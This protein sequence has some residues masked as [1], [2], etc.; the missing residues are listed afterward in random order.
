MGNRLIK[1]CLIIKIKQIYKKGLGGFREGDFMN[2][3]GINKD[4]K[5]GLLFNIDIEFKYKVD[6][7]QQV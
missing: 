6:S 4:I 5:E 2:R 1:K 7:S 3:S